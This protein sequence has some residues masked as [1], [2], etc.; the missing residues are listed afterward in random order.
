MTIQLSAEQ[1]KLIQDRVKSGQY[2]SVEAMI[3]AAIIR[4]IQEE[5]HFAPGELDALIAEG[6]A[7]FER[8]DTI[9]GEAAFDQLRQK[10]ARLRA[11]RR[12]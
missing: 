6:E 5:P 12:Q 11:E 2:P 7:D 3:S 10:S 9:D 4:L 1:E 8:G